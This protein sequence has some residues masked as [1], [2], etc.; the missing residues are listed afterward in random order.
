M[1]HKNT[2]DIFIALAV[3]LS[4]LVLLA[5]LFYAVVGFPV[6]AGRALYVDMPSIT[7]LRVHSQVRYAGNPVG[8]ITGIRTLDWQERTNPDCPIRLEIQVTEDL[9]A[10][11]V[12]SYASITAD[13]ILAEKF[14]DI[15][16][17][18]A[19][20]APL[21]QGQPIPA[22]PGTQIGDLLA[23]GSRLLADLGA[24]AAELRSDYPDFRSSLSGMFSSLDEVTTDAG[25][26]MNNAQGLLTHA[27]GVLRNGDAAAGDLRALLAKADSLAGDADA[28]VL[29]TDAVVGRADELL[30][31]LD[32]LVSG[33]EGRW[34]QTLGDLRV[35][36]QNLKVTST[37]L[38]IFSDRVSREPWRLVWGTRRQVEIPTPEE[39]LRTR[40][41]AVVPAGE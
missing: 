17:G 33:Q 9:P 27:G 40:E 41:E 19:S 11:K 5:A 28:L 26:L 39:I 18:T 15:A 1:K 13:T 22:A 31:G 21:A 4:S 37:Y 24:L 29:K 6:G 14:L 3:V 7:G 2:S 25:S 23:T 10:L 32:Q 34:D 38:K 16:P 20:A 30:T 36:L 8:R 35:T 12:D